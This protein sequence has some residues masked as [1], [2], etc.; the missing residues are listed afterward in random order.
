[1]PTTDFS[2]DSRSEQFFPVIIVFSAS[3]CSPINWQPAPIIQ[4]LV[5]LTADDTTHLHSNRFFSPIF[6]ASTREPTS[7]TLFAPITKTGGLAIALV[8]SPVSWIMVVYSSIK[9][10]SPMIIGPDF[11]MIVTR[12]WMMHPLETVISPEKVLSSHSQTIAFGIIFSLKMCKKKT[13]KQ[14]IMPNFIAKRL[15]L[16]LTRCFCSTFSKILYSIL[17]FSISLFRF[18]ASHKVVL[19]ENKLSVYL[20]NC[21][22]A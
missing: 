11:A 7:N 2:I 6:S 18:K 13:N 5:T 1:M 15:F 17:S 9:Q 12:G 21:D 4:L 20:S 16:V 3:V 10:F 14:N 22:G 19:N 8:S